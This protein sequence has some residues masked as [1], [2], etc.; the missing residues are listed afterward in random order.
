MIVQNQKQKLIPRTVP[1]GR[2]RILRE[3]NRWFRSLGATSEN[4]PA[5]RGHLT[6]GTVWPRIHQGAGVTEGVNIS[7]T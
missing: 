2:K 6:A 3:R 4:A 5:Q 7:V 1:K